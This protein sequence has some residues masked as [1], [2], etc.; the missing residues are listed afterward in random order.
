MDVRRDPREEKA[1]KS[2]DDVLA[3][4]EEAVEDL[5]VAEDDAENVKGGLSFNYSKIKFD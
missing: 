5:D 1:E 2:P 3:K 4:Q